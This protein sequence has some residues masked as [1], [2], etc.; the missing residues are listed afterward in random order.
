VTVERARREFDA[1]V[2]WLPF[3]LHPEFPEEGVPLA[4]LH[5]RF[6][7][8]VGAADPMRARFEAAGLEYRRP[9]IVPNT[10]TA[11]RVTELA[12]ELDLHDAFHE[13]LMDAYWSEAVNVGD[14]DEL[15]RLAAEVGLPADEVERVLADPGAFSDLVDDSTRQAH[16]I[17]VNGIPAFLL[18]RRLLILGAQPLESF[19]QAFAQL[20]AGR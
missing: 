20:A 12:R 9:E 8:G 17:G 16:S 11:L 4:E 7:I 15:R 6:G 18:D 3:M 13:R 5:A 14:H 19:R 2:V 10:R 1:D